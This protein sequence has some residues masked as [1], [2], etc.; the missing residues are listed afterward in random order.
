MLRIRCGGNIL[1]E[2]IEAGEHA[3][4][5]ALAGS[6]N[7]FVQRFAGD[8][9]PGHAARGAI[10]SDP[11]GEALVFSKLEQRR[12]EHARII[13]AAWEGRN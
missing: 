3:R 13:M 2:V 7:G 10:G 4:V 12:P 9:A 1:A 11:I 6:G 5:I 8:E